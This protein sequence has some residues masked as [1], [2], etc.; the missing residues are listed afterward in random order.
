M[1]GT[2]A[3]T[4]RAADGA[5]YRMARSTNILPWA[6][7]NRA[8]LDGAPVHW[9]AVLAQW[10]A[11]M[12]DYARGRASGR[13]DHAMTKAYASESGILAPIHYGLV[14]VDALTR[15]ILSCQ[16]YSTPGQVPVPTVQLALLG[17]R[18]P[19]AE[20]HA[21]VTE[22]ALRA[23]VGEQASDDPLDQSDL[24]RFLA[25]Y[26]AGRIR[27]VLG[28]RRRGD[29]VDPV[30][31]DLTGMTLDQILAELA[32]QQEQFGRESK[33]APDDGDGNAPAVADAGAAPATWFHFLVDMAPWTCEIF[34]EGDPEALRAMRA[35]VEALGFALTVDDRR[36]WD[37][38]IADLTRDED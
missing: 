3:L 30:Q 23:Y 10:R 11:M 13:F 14:V 28:F 25:L 35:R 8:L 17:L 15:T 31:V 26:D 37:D 18:R 22:A 24:D 1:G 4:L 32:R 21:P 7:T 12:A 38:A 33:D 16:G 2:V 34:S 5:E 9:E 6:V 20:R 27:E 36:R 29:T 19:R